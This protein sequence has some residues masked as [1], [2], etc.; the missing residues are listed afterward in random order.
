MTNES[1][2]LLAGLLF[3]GVLVKGW[4][5]V[6]I[7]KNAFGET[8]GLCFLGIFVW[9][10]AIMIGW[11]WLL[12]ISL[13]L[14]T[15]DLWILGL[16]TSVFWVVRGWGEATYWLNQQF[17][18]IVRN[19]PE[20][21]RGYGLVKSDAIWFIYQVWWQTIMMLAGISTILLVYYRLVGR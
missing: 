4:Q 6:V 1:G 7:R 18:P 21:L 15:K 5:E 11:F 2:L 12:A 10:D 20:K 16:F 8:P 13:A 14:I 19:P 17:S 3:L 9:G